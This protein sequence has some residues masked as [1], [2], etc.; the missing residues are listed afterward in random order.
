MNFTYDKPFIYSGHDR[1]RYSALEIR[2]TLWHGAVIAAAAAQR[3]RPAHVPSPDAGT[4]SGQGPSA[5]MG[6][7]VLGHNAAPGCRLICSGEGAGYHFL[8]S[9]QYS[10]GI[11]VRRP[12]AG[13]S[14]GNES[15]T[16]ATTGV[17]VA[18][19]TYTMSPSRPADGPPEPQPVQI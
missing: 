10:P 12:V 17:D 8:Q 15:D 6:V 18:V 9:G 13:F 4:S 1:Q 5:I 2:K 3:D 11:K 14:L 7:F 16:G 19:S